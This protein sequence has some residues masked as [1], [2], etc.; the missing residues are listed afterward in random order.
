MKQNTTCLKPKEK[1]IISS[2]IQSTQNTKQETNL[3]QTRDHRS[4]FCAAGNRETADF[5]SC[6]SVGLR[7][8]S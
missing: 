7:I 2:K 1:N 5:N 3:P 6:T 8:I 4:V